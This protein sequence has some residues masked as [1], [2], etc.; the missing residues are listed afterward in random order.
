MS[1]IRKY[2]RIILRMYRPDRFKRDAKRTADICLPLQTLALPRVGLNVIS[3][4][5]Y[6]SDTVQFSKSEPRLDITYLQVI[7]R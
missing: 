6:R 5:I 4:A 1:R 3:Y 2:T 7:F